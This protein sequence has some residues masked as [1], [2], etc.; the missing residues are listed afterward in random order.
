M[1]ILL[2]LLNFG[3]SCLNAWS[4][5]RSWVEARAVGGV[6]RFMAWMGAIMAAV[7]FTWSYLAILAMICNGFHLLPPL[8]IQGMFSLGYLALIIPALGSGLAITIQSW[9]IF[10]KN[11][12]IGNGAAASWNTFAQIYNMYEAVQYIP[13]ALTNVKDMFSSDDD[14]DSKSQLILLAVLLAVGAVAGGILTAR[15]I[16]L[17]VARNVAQEYATASR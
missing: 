9:A 4:V 6:V 8:Y 16:I 7:G 2:I 17:H 15:A 14:D 1:I 13:E 12:T 3:L 10:W 5:G 11:K